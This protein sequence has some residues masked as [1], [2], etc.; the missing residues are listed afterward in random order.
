MENFKEACRGGIIGFLIGLAV[1]LVGHRAHA[2]DYVTLAFGPSVDGTTN[3]KLAAAGYEKTWGE[4]SIYSHCGAL[5]EDP[6]NPFCAVVPGVHIETVSGIFTRVG[7]GPALFTH[8]NSRLSSRPE[9]NISFAL[10]LVQNGFIVGLE[11]DHFSN[12][13]LPLASPNPNLGDDHVSLLVEFF[14]P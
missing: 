13:G 5:F 14:I 11:G 4:F 9:F 7:V 3:P 12:G 6:I 10:G 8:T 1:I 2:G